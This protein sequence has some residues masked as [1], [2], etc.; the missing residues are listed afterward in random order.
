MNPPDPAPILDLI[1]AFRRSK[2]MFTAVSLGVFE[3]LREG[4][5]ETV[6]L[7][8]RLGVQPDALQRLLEACAGMGLLQKTNGGYANQPVTEAYLCDQSPLS[9]TGY[10]LY[11]DEALFPMWAHLE[12]AIREGSHRWTQT[13]GWQGSLFE[14]F[15]KTPERRRSFLRGMHGFGQL[16]SP[17]VVAAFDLS[18]FTRLVDLGGATGHLALAACVRYPGMHATVFDL[19][20]VID[21][22]KEY[23]EVSP[24]RE[25]VE[26]FR[27]DF[28]QDELPTGDLYALGR[29]LHDWR[30]DRIRM[31]L[32]KIYQALPP[33]GALLLAEKL[34]AEDRSGPGH[35]HLQSLNMLVCTEGKERT[36][37]EYTALL[38]EAGFAE[39]EGRRTGTPLDAVL[40]IRTAPHH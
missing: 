7:A 26:L 36:L 30:E 4:P 38:H 19:P 12:D 5:F 11:S 9:M 28:F 25:R 17:A 20:V 21:I 13:F 15:F 8:A 33:G 22:A 34:L 29:I 10:I 37:S 35:V 2:A 14:H 39:V 32:R 23:V 27:G 3:A 40:A 24:V 18:R 1:D 6:A 16:S 31:L